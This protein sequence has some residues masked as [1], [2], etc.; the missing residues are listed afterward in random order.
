MQYIIVMKDKTVFTT[1]WYSSENNWTDTIYCVV[2][3]VLDRATFDGKSWVE[4]EH[5]HL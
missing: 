2:D 5:D 4:V 3:T 1:D